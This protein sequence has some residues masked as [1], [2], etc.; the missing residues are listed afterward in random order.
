LILNLAHAVDHPTPPTAAVLIFEFS[1]SGRNEQHVEQQGCSAVE[2]PNLL[3]TVVEVVLL[4][5]S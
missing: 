1:L 2:K 4:S 3:L 5:C